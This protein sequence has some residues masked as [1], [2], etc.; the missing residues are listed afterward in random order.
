MARFARINSQIRANRLIL[1]NR[2]RV[3]EANPE[4]PG[5]EKIHSRSNAWKN[6]SPTHKIFILAWNFHS[7]FENFILDWKFQ[8]Q[9]LFFCGQRGARN[10]NFILDW[11]FHSVLKAWFFQ[12]RLS[13]LNFFNPGAL[14]EPLFCESRFGGLKIANRRF[15]AIRAN[16]SNFVKIGV[17]LRIDSRES[18]RAIARFALRIA[19]PSTPRLF[20]DDFQDTV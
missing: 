18:I 8:S 11:K 2:F 5:I 19:G 14:W 9:A 3:P 12:Y 4:G 16:R 20:W 10:E 17:F 6:H 1:V 7:R 15:E 13:R